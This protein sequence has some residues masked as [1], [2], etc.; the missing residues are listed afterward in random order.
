[1]YIYHPGIL[2]KLFPLII[3][4]FLITSFLILM[5]FS[6]QVQLPNKQNKQ[7]TWVFFQQL[8]KHETL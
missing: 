4:I 7:T 3:V 1:M 6:K 2:L 5:D 8:K